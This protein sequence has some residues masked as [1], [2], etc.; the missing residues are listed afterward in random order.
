MLIFSSFLLSR[1]LAGRNPNIT[2]K[3]K[4][5]GVEFDLNPMYKQKY[6]FV[7]YPSDYNISLG[8]ADY[9]TFNFCQDTATSNGTGCELLSKN[10]SETT[11]VL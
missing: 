1:A 11:A 4:I 9:I 5:D 6:S 7:S 8:G 2:C 10:S 3:P